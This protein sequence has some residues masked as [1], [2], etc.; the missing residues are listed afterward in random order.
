MDTMD[1]RTALRLAGATGAAAFAGAKIIDPAASWAGAGSRFDP[2]LTLV[3][4]GHVLATGPTG[5]ELDELRGRIVATVAQ[6]ER[7][8]TGI[9]K[10][11]RGPGWSAVLAGPPLRPG[12]ADAYGVA[13][14]ENRDGSFEW[15]PWQMA[16]TLR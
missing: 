12:K 14:I 9:S 15:Y 1:R 6:G 4:D 11:T 2:T 5:F 13:Y 7:V 16:V 10:W 8:E 3:D